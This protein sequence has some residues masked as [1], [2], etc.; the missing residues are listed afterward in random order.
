MKRKGKASPSIEN[1]QTAKISKITSALEKGNILI[2]E[3]TTAGNSVFSVRDIR[4]SAEIVSHLVGEGTLR[5]FEDGLFYGFSQTFEFI[6]PIS[7]GSS[8]EDLA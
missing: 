2:N 7:S 6:S 3:T 5:P 4:I 1:R 8:E